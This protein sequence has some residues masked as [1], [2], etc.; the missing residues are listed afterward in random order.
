MESGSYSTLSL[1]TRRDAETW[2]AGCV[3][4]G[5]A[6]EVSIR[7]GNPSMADIEK[8]MG[9]SAK[10]LFFGGHFG[11]QT[12]LNED[13]STKMKF[14]ESNVVCT[15]GGTTKTLTRGTEF[16]LHQT[17]MVILWGGC[18]V[19]S[20]GSTIRALRSLFGNH[21]LLGFAGITGWKIVDAMLG[22]GFIK[23]HFF[24]RSPSTSDMD[25]LARAWLNTAVSGYGAGSIGEMIRAVEYTGQEWEIEGGKIQKGRKFD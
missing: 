10:W 13:G 14:S 9:G 5:L 8:F 15:A 6:E 17:A 16:N 3:R 2:N 7:S 23:K 20:G 21:V 11:G 12:L 25:A 24:A 18:N 4:L 19:C 22:G 1:G